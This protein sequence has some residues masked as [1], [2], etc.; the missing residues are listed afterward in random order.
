MAMC[1]MGMLE[2]LP[3]NDL[4]DYYVASDAWSYHRF[5]LNGFSADLGPQQAALGLASLATRNDHRGRP[6]FRS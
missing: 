1:L 3:D 4:A 5:Y 2:D 6:P